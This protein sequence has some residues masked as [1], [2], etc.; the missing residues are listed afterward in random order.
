MT[1]LNIKV[2]SIRRTLNE[3]VQ[4]DPSQEMRAVRHKVIRLLGENLGH[5]DTIEMSVFAAFLKYY[6]FS[7]MQICILTNRVKVERP[8]VELI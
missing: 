5:L 4:E 7:D 8:E 6:N 3:L 1:V 2:S